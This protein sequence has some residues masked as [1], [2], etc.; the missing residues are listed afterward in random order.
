[1]KGF[2]RE[3]RSRDSKT[4]AD[5]SG[6][7]SQVEQVPV[8]RIESNDDDFTTAEL[9]EFLEADGYDV[10][11]DPAF[12]ENLREMLWQMVKRMRR[13]GGEGA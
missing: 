7:T 12:K 3:R 2:L 5:S 11:A 6:T 9:Q 13:D 1:M 10:P 8:D 4:V